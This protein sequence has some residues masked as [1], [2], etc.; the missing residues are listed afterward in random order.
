MKESICEIKDIR[1]FGAVNTCVCE[2]LL[3]HLDVPRAPE[4]RVVAL[5]LDA[6]ERADVAL[7]RED[8]LGLRDL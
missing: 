3:T 6:L 4:P 7:A 5:Q 8:V 2:D 1:G